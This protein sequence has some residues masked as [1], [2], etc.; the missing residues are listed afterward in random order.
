MP[1][2]EFTYL[3]KDIPLSV[4]AELVQAYLEKAGTLGWELIDVSYAIQGAARYVFKLEIGSARG[5]RPEPTWNADE[6]APESQAFTYVVQTVWYSILNEKKTQA[7]LQE[8]AAKR[9]ELS[10]IKPGTADYEFYIFRVPLA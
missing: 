9:W 3:L 5:T 1:N 4:P 7:V 10:M 2:R 8:A 6:V